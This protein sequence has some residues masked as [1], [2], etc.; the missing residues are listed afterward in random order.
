RAH[1]PSPPSPPLPIASSP[2]V[3][4][5]VL[6]DLPRAAIGLAVTIGV[7]VLFGF[8]SSAGIGAWAA[9]IGLT[10]L[11]T[12]ALSWVAAVIG[13][14]GRSLEV[15]QQLAAVIILPVFLSNALVPTDT[16]PDWLRGVVANQPISQATDAIRALLSNQPVG[17]HLALALIE[18]AAIAVLAFIIATLLF[19]RAAT[20]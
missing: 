1:V 2:V 5:P 14:L 6:S 16:L 7:G 4:G 10:L 17:D 20:R 11:V 18:L 12:F 19:N 3:T 15:V 9:A 8:R 13:L